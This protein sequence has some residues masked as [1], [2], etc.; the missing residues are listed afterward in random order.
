M[1]L[2]TENYVQG[3]AENLDKLVAEKDVNITLFSTKFPHDVDVTID[4]HNRMKHKNRIVVNK[5]NLSPE[6]IIEIS[7]EQDLLLEQ[8]FIP[9]T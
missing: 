4:V 8:D 7:S 2:N 6:E 3:M 5:N 1:I 9:Y